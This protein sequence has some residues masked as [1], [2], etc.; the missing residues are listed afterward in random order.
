MSSGI[1]ELEQLARKNQWRKVEAMV[2]KHS[3]T[4][5]KEAERI[6]LARLARR[7][8][9]VALGLRLLK[10]LVK[11][12]SSEIRSNAP[13]SALA[14]FATCLILLGARKTAL[15]VLQRLELD[16]PDN[17]FA[18]V[19]YYFSIQEFAQ[20]AFY[21][22]SL[23]ENANDPYQRK[24]GELNLCA[25]LI[26]SDKA[27]DFQEKLNS[28][29][30]YFQKNSHITLLSNTFELEGQWH[31][32]QKRWEK[33][34]LSLENARSVMGDENEIYDFFIEKWMTIVK[35]HTEDVVFKE[36]LPLIR[37]CNE[38]GEYHS[39]RD[40]CR[41]WA[42]VK[43]D[44][45]LMEKVYFGTSCKSYRENLIKENPDLAQ[46][47]SLA[48]NGSLFQ[49]QW[50]NELHFKSTDGTSSFSKLQLR[51]IES[52]T[53]DFFE[54][55][56]VG[57]LFESIF[58]GEYFDPEYSLAKTYKAIQRLNQKFKKRGVPV[59]VESKK[60]KYRL[61][62]D[63]GWMIRVFNPMVFENNDLSHQECQ[64]LSLF[65]GQPFRR[66]DVEKSFGISRS[67]AGRWL[68]DLQD[69]NLVIK[70]GESSG[71]FYRLVS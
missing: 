58:P 60:N 14:E 18:W 16:Q 11:G 68:K 31:I 59:H 20:A 69:K 7:A 35:M 12:P 61:F 30:D 36:I 66:Q 44:K 28:L 37:R 70:I 64:L 55:K 48:W 5:L 71:S 63:D 4:S 26:Y 43:G 24:I 1:E 27:G 15:R 57:A 33:A 51:I 6:H 67:S 46:T 42:E 9:K 32:T 10:P 8:N 25:C 13:Q 62:V 53:G 45:T 2:L 47:G 39:L 3:R 34:Q 52:L 29:K 21:V 17:L 40:I 22:K 19:S 56:S 38:L 23:I 65:S 50:E 49:H 54:A 41:H